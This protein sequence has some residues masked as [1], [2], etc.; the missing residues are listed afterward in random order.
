[1]LDAGGRIVATSEEKERIAALATGGLVGMYPATA[2]LP[3]W[4]VAECARLALAAA[5]RRRGPLARLGA[6]A[7]RAC[8]GLPDAFAA[9]HHPAEPRRGRRG[10]PTGCSSTRRFATQLTMAYR[11]ADAASHAGAA[12]PAACRT[13][14][15]DA[16][17]AR[18]PFRSPRARPRSAT[19]IFAD[20]ARARPMQRLLQGEVGSGKTVV[21]LRAML[22]VVDAGGQAALLAPDRGARAPALPDHH[23]RCS[24]TSAPGAC[25]APPT[26]PP[27]WC[28]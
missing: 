12:P 15:L 3:T 10:A 7:A 27:T 6:G 18:L 4:K 2:K 28:C 25:W 23:A 13:G 21:A 8:C 11:R 22:A 26:R 14:L 1:M 9:V 17:D 20:L 16:F 5:V 19:A 24:A